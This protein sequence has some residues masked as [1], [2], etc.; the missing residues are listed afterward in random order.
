MD[1]ILCRKTATG[2][3]TKA[4]FTSGLYGS[5]GLSIAFCLS[6]TLPGQEERAEMGRRPGDERA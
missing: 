4:Y 2:P 1:W 3:A 6:L 5:L